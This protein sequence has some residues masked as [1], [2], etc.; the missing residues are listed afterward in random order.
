VLGTPDDLVRSGIEAARAVAAPRVTVPL[1]LKIRRRL[2]ALMG[3][4]AK[5]LVLSLGAV[6]AL[7]VVATVIIHLG[8]LDHATHRHLGL[9][10]STYFTVETVATVGFGDYS[11][12]TQ[13]AWLQVF[14]IVLITVGVTLVTTSFALFTNLLVSRRIEQ[15]LGRRRVPGMAGHVVVVG[16]GAVGI[17]VV[18]GLLAEGRQVVVVE[19]D[20]GNR[21]LDRAR[22]LGVPV[23]IADA[24]SIRPMPRSTSPRRQLWPSSPVPT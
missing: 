20:D 21:Y 23:V 1:A 2:R 15:S 11:F 24:P 10:A 9:L 8:Y 17:R 4:N 3:S 14:A 18:E 7:V 19:R 12:A 6:L 22:A 16:L 5:G 13:S